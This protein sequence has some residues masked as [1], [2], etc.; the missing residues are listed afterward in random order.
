MSRTQ[1]RDV[2]TCQP[3]MDANDPGDLIPVLAQML[4]TAIRSDYGMT[5]ARWAD[6]NA[7]RVVSLLLVRR[8]SRGE[9]ARVG[10]PGCVPRRSMPARPRT[11]SITCPS[12]P[13]PLLDAMRTDSEVAL[14]DG[15]GWE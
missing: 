14:R 3:I 9:A 15:E 1:N 11:A 10:P 2:A 6:C 13:N 8:P 5:I 12:E 7:P 4:A